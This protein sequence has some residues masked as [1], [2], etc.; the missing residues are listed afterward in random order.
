MNIVTEI[1]NAE[2]GSG[3]QEQVSEAQ[4]PKTP[5]LSGKYEARSFAKHL[6][7]SLKSHGEKSR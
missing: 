6:R 4:E 2:T 1:R 7:E 3:T 5:D